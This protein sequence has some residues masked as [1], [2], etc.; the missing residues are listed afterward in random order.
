MYEIIKNE[1][2]LLLAFASLLCGIFV[3]FAIALCMIRKPNKKN[4]YTTYWESFYKRN[5]K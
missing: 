4:E 1:P 3:M 5:S 2:L